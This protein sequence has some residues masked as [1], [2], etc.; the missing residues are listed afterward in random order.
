VFPAATFAT[1]LTILATLLGGEVHSRILA[2]DGGATL[3][4]R[5]VSAW[6]VHLVLVLAALLANGY[7]FVVEVATVREN[8]LGI[9]EINRRLSRRDE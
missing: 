8:R 7:A 1:V 6:W 3:P 4:L 9:E 2:I 5:T